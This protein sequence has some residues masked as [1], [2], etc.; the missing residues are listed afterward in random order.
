MAGTARPMT[1][2][3][4]SHRARSKSRLSHSLD[5][6]CVSAPIIAPIVAP[7]IMKNSSMLEKKPSFSM[8][9]PFFFVFMVDLCMYH[10]Q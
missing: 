10:R 7:I 1:T 2:P 6:S 3:T 9:P 8:L 5:V 4:A